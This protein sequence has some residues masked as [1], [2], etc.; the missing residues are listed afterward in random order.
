MNFLD[1]LAYYSRPGTRRVYTSLFNKHIKPLPAKL[2]DWSWEYY[3]RNM[4][5]SWLSDGLSPSTIKIL[6]RLLRQYVDWS[7]DYKVNTTP[8]VRWVM[9]HKQKNLVKA[10]D[11]EDALRLLYECRGTKLYLPVAIALHTGM[12]RG[13]VWGLKQT[14]VNLSTKL[15]LVERSYDGPTK[16]G[17]SRVIPISNSLFNILSSTRPTKNKLVM[18]TKFDP[19][20]ALKSICKQA[21][22]P[23]ITFHGLRHTF[24][25]QALNKGRNIRELADILGHASVS[26]TMDIYWN[27]LNKMNMG[28]FDE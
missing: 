19:N 23:V 4:A 8:I 9:S 7:N 18:P 6:L 5:E 16:N 10:L 15:I 3:F 27:C 12:R 11:K 17:H 14:N 13:E 25:T 22:L 2:S 24:A 26:T 21:D 20:P 28:I 1:T